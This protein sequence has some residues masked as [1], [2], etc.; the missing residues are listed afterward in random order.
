MTGIKVNNLAGRNQQALVMSA[1]L[2]SGPWRFCTL[3]LMLALSLGAIAT[4]PVALG[5]IQITPAMIQQL[6]SMRL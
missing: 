3:A 4:A 2:G 5:Q 1:V 6:Q